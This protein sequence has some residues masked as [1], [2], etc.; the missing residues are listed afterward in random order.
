MLGAHTSPPLRLVLTCQ[1][2]LSDDLEDQLLHGFTVAQLLP[3]APDTVLV[4]QSQKMLLIGHHK[5]N[6]I[7]LIAAVWEVRRGVKSQEMRRVQLSSYSGP[8]VY[9]GNGMFHQNGVMEQLITPRTPCSVDVGVKLPLGFLFSTPEY[10]MG[11]DLR[12]IVWPFRTGS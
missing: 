1:S 2:S 10:T 9:N 11:P 8:C 4:S 3:W 5:A 7:R 6:H 12:Q